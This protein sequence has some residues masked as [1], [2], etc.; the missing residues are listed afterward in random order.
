M[1][2]TTKGK[3]EKVRNIVN[4]CKINDFRVMIKEAMNAFDK[5]LSKRKLDL[6][7]WGEKE[8]KEF[9]RIFGSRGDEIVNI[10][11]PIRGISNIKS[12]TAREV[13]LDCIRRLV[14]IRGQ[15]TVDSFI[16][17]INIHQD[18]IISSDSS[19][20]NLPKAF[21]AY[22][23]P[24]QQKDFKIY[25]GINFTGRVNNNAIRNCAAVT[26]IDSRVATLCHEM[27]HFE[28][29]FVD[30]TL[31]GMGTLDYESDGSKPLPN[32]DN[33]SYIGHL[34]GADKLVRTGNKNVFNN[35]YNIERYFQIVI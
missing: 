17:K 26:G 34:N 27:S 9:Y 23:I 35:A 20:I 33:S 15:L 10:D 5:V 21:A 13:M 3:P 4:Q 11:M 30:P 19:D 24:T 22:V 1:R 2:D 12:M 18:P 16:N 6:E 7:T 28:K 31:G 8:Q 29:N 14:W 32:Q 25:I